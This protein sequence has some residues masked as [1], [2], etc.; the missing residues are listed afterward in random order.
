MTHRA[1]I[2]AALKPSLVEWKQESDGDRDLCGLPLKP[3]LV[4]WKLEL[5][6]VLGDMPEP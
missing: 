2:G 4:E 5:L 3:S 1:P 6:E